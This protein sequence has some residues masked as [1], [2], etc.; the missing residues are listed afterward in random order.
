MKSKELLRRYLLFIFSLLVSGIGV[1]FTKTGALGV[2]PISSLA[3]VLSIRFPEITIGNWLII[4]NLALIA[5]QIL[6]LRRRFR[7]IELLQIPLSFLFGYF[8]DFGMWIASF[9]PVNTYP[10]QLVMVCLG[11]A[12][13]GLGIALSVTANVIMNAGEAFV[14]VLSDLL[15]KNF[16]SVKIAFDVSIVTFSALLSLLLF[17]GRLEG[18]REGTLIA[19]LCT[20]LCVKL[21]VR[22]IRVP[23]EKILQDHTT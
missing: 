16:G 3:N 9:V 18:I 20:G 14:R 2:S 6:I 7:L 21:F 1:A 15:N 4:T 19:A 23:L 17:S 10:M 12:I 5:G 11:T 8:T 13:L 22:L